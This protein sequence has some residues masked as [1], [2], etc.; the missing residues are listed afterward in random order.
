MTVGISGGLSAG[1]MTAN[2][3]SVGD[4]P[5][6]SVVSAINSAGVGVTA[7]PT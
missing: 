1:S 7:K 6:Q 4:G 2:N 5:L 3:V